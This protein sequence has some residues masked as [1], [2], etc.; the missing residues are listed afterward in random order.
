[1][2][3]YERIFLGVFA[4]L[5]AVLSKFMAQDYTF[6]VA[7]ASNLTA[8]QIF[9]FKVGYG[10]LTP[11]L[12]LMGGFVAWVSEENKRMKVAAL[13]ISAP[14]LITTWAGGPDPNRGRAS[15]DLFV[16]SAYAQP[17]TTTQSETSPAN[18]DAIKDIG[19]WERVQKGVGIFFGHGK[20]PIRYRVI[21]GSY[22]DRDAAQR[23]ADQLN[24]ENSRLNAWVADRRPD[25]PHYPVVVGG[26][27]FL[28]TANTIKDEALKMKSV[29]NAYLSAEPTK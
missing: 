19:A 20:E 29:K 3:T 23:F 13:A 22:K 25:N 15:L 1:M 12:A 10:I 11:V 18:R 14:A 9:N 8:E 21:V 7:H 28:T 17:S 24:K 27:N 6:V 4:G 26:Y 16:A 2:S 5:I